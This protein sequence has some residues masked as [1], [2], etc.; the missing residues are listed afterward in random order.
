MTKTEY[1]QRRK[2][3]MKQIGNDNIAIIATSPEFPRSKDIFFSFYPNNNFYYLTGFAEP[4]AVAI[5]IPNEINDIFIL[6]NR[7][8]DPLQKI[9][10]GHHE[11]QNGV[12]KNFGADQAYSID[13]LALQ[14]PKLLKNK[15]KLFYQFDLFDNIISTNKWQKFL[16]QQIKTEITN[17]KQC[18]DINPLIHEMRLIKSP[19]ELDLLRKAAN[20]NVKAH[21][22]AMRQCK[23]GMSEIQLCAELNYI[24]GQHNCVEMAYPPIVA[25]GVNACTLH[26]LAGEK[27]LS[28][29]EMVLIDMGQEYQR[30]TSDV[31]RTFPVNGTFSMAQKTLYELVLRT[32]LTIIEAI[33]PGV[34]FN[35]LQDL[36]IKYITNGLITLGILKG[37]AEQLIATKAYA[38]FYMHQISHWLGLDTHDVGSYKIEDK[39]RTLQPGMVLTVEPGIYIQEHNTEVAKKWHGMGIRIEDDIIVTED[40]YENITA[41][42]PKTVAEIEAIMA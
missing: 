37:D 12:I 31:T 2:T 40:G 21:T 24:Y 27:I 42:A 41:A 22:Y 7:A 6:F 4:D 35:T 16:Q 19:A 14:L 18:C 25:G 1:Q 36:A 29:G 26:Y 8:H 3:L 38:N 15:K 32:Q 9:W 34:T 13:D 20:I 33:K 10:H 30:Y 11:G 28:D 23:A 39:W 17:N 5:L